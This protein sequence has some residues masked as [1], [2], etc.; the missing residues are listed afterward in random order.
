MQS[1]AH[2][3]ALV[4]TAQSAEF[5]G[6]EEGVCTFRIPKHDLLYIY[7][8]KFTSWIYNIPFQPALTLWPAWRHSTPP[9]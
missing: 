4:I 7:I 9:P 2:A 1:L 5:V 8:E 6:M 3:H